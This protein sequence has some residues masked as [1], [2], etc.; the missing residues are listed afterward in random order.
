MFKTK[1]S[2]SKEHI[3][4]VITTLE[5]YKNK[6]MSEDYNIP[7]EVLEKFITNNDMEFCR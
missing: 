3:Q 2:I 5:E 6:N 4:K 1:I 7:K